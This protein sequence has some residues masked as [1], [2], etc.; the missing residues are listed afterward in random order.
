MMRKGRM[1]VVAAVTAWTILMALALYD[2]RSFWP[3]TPLATDFLSFW[4]GASLI[5][6]G[7]GPALY[8]MGTQHALEWKVLSMTTTID[9]T[10]LVNWLDPYHTPPPL[11]LIFVPL[12]WLPIPLGY[13]LWSAVSLG[14]FIA[15]IALPLRGL[16]DARSVAIL[17]ITIGP[18]ADNLIWGQVDALFLLALSLS[19]LLLSR[20]KP[21]LGGV[22]LGFLWL[23]PQYAVLFPLIFLIK[24]RWRELGGM[25]V[26]GL[27]FAALS[28][29]IVR[30]EGVI[31][32]AEVLR[33]IGEFRP[34]VSSFILPEIMIN[35]RGLLINLW[36]SVPEA[37]GSVLMVVLGLVTALVSLLAWR[38]DWDPSSSRFPRQ[39]LATVVATLL[40]IPHSHFHGLVLLLAPLGLAVSR[41]MPGARLTRFWQPFLVVGDLLCYVLWPMEH[42]RWLMMPFLMAAMLVLIAQCWGYPRGVRE[43]R[44]EG[45]D[46]KESV[47]T[48]LRLSRFRAV[49]GR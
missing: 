20:G 5:R 24:G 23:K 18:I 9:P 16:R 29:V 26:T 40:A 47:L 8:D 44:M 33:R 11:A 49:P 3:D 15:A 36:P 39:M 1:F 17:M 6:D 28:L 21:F 13:L 42:Q 32:Y 48:R 25:A 22:L 27:V 10:K 2:V 31:I 7:V 4:T 19:L 12:T 30:P 41:P 34:P 37:T 46:A 43:L 45:G 38:G 14:A 35:W